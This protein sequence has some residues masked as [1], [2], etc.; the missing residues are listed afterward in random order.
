MKRYLAA[1]LFLSVLLTTGCWFTDRVDTPEGDPTVIVEHELD[2]DGN[3]VVSGTMVVLGK[4][5]GEDLG[6]KIEEQGR[7]LGGP[8]GIALGFI[9]GLIAGMSRKAARKKKKKKK[10]K[11]G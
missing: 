9:G 10:T 7:N 4:T 1:I 11:T 3:L 5:K 6:E 2:S 8:V